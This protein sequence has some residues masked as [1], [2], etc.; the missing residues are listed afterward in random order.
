MLLYSICQSFIILLTSVG[1]T[2]I[3]LASFLILVMCVVIFFI[4]ILLEIGSTHLFEEPTFVSLFFCI[5]FLFSVLLN[6]AFYLYYLLSSCCLDLFCSSS[7]KQHLESQLETSNVSIQCPKLTAL[8]YF[9]CISQI[10]M[11]VFS[12]SFSSMCFLLP[13]RFF[14]L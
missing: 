5:I 10:L 8:Y 4:V 13:L 11:F 7:L 3:F 6:F 9:S 14:P 2:V 1:P 12:F